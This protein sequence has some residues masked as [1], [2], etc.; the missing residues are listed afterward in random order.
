M[1]MGSAPRREPSL[2]LTRLATWRVLAFVTFIVCVAAT[3]S[4]PRATVPVRYLAFQIFTSGFD[5]SQLRQALPPPPA[6]LRRTIVDLRDR[7]GTA[8]QRDRR[9]GFVLGPISFDTNDADVRALIAS[10]FDIALSSG[11]AVGFH[12]DDSMFW[13]RLQNL[14]THQNIEWLDWQGTPNTGR[15]LDW[16]L[17]PMEI[18][19]QLCINSPEVRAA[20]AQRATLIGNA[21]AHGVARLRRAHREDLYLGVIAGSEAQIGR[22]FATGRSLGYCALT[23]AGYSAAHPPADMDRT[24]G[25]IIRKFSGYWATSLIAAGAPADK[26]YSHIAYLSSTMYEVERRVHPGDARTS[27]LQTINYTPPAVAFCDGCRP[28]LS[29]YP[30]PGHLE[31]WQREL[32][33]HGDPPWASSEGTAIDPSEAERS[34]KPMSME[35][36]LGNLFNHG[37]VLV[38]VFGWGVGNANNPFRKIAESDDAL[39]AYRRF[40]DGRTLAEA[41]IPIP[42]LPPAGLADK[43]RAIAVKLPAWVDAHGPTLVRDN[44]DK[45]QKALADKR[46]DDADRAADAILRTIGA[47]HGVS[48]TRLRHVS[49]FG[50]GATRH[51]SHAV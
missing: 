9:L 22:D 44:A 15:R 10:G 25:E 18:M 37:A 28:G 21:I 41:P 27:Y 31:Q 16:S 40:L 20:V 3:A 7:I 46:Y 24:L 4:A 47:P 13:G 45:L 2:P 8:G 39:G 32:D 38:N 36:Y 17:K 42:V 6:E 19:P 26:V 12:I 29:T 51:C 35:G 30:Q 1:A 14:N 23:N 48:R 11:A 50:T 49:S 34:G 43:V 5:S 33:K